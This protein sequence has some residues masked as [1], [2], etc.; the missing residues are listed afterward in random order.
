[1]KNQYGN[2]RVWSS[3][4]SSPAW[5]PCKPPDTKSS[6]DVSKESALSHI[7]SE[8]PTLGALGQGTRQQGGSSARQTALHSAQGWQQRARGARMSQ[9]WDLLH[10][11][12]S[13]LTCPLDFFLAFSTDFTVSPAA[14]RAA[15][16]DS[17]S[18]IFRG[19]KKNKNQTVARGS[20]TV[21]ICHHWPGFWATQLSDPNP[22]LTSLSAFCT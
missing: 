3:A 8:I 7:L 9:R 13:M 1:M 12:S 20:I 6:L 15:I 11:P 10:P 5:P 17:M 18:D 2:A 22:T 19:R 14:D 21:L 4:C 16:R